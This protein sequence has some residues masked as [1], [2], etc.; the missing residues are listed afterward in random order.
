MKRI[1]AIFLVLI[2]GLMALSACSVDSSKV[3]AKGDTRKIIAQKYVDAIFAEDYNELGK[4]KV[5]FQMRINLLT[6]LEYKKVK[7]TFIEACGEFV[8]IF[9]AFE[10]EQGEFWIVSAACE[11]EKTFADINIDFDKN[12]RIAGIHYVYNRIYEDMGDSETLIMFGGENPLSGSLAV[13][14]SDELSPAVIIVHGSGP[15]DRNGAV[16]G[17]AVYLDLA[18]QLYDYGIAS[19]RYDKR[20]YAYRNMPEGYYNNITVWQETIDDVVEAF[21]FLKVQNGID[22][23]QIYIVGHSLS[24]YLM[25]RIANEI[26]DAAGFVMLAPSASHLEDLI[27]MQTE[28]INNLDG[29]VTGEEDRA[30]EDIKTIRSRIKNLKPNSGYS[31]TELF[32]APESYWLDLADYNPIIEMQKEDRPIL[33]IQGGRDYQV[34]K[35]EFELWKKGL[36]ENENAKFILLPYL[37]HMFAYGEGHSSPE[38]YQKLSAVDSEVGKTIS[39][40]ILSNKENND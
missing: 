30:L 14:G 6:R 15:S 9:D 40:F 4:F 24:G 35:S 32:F 36:G 39:N 7:S 13:P 1:T 10:S 26:P 27:V 21:N 38:E 17:N 3:P 2:M 25:P 31:S 23:N 37:N 12:N 29:K 16:G 34:D 20:T 28:Y 5:T 19:L 8:S 22:P 33:V 11:F 18:R